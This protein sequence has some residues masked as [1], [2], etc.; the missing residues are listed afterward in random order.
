MDGV[1]WLRAGGFFFRFEEAV[2]GGAVD[3]GVGV[4]L[5][6]RA[7]DEDEGAEGAFEFV[8]VVFFVLAEFEDVGGAIPGGGEGSVGGGARVARHLGFDGLVQQRDG[9]HVVPAAAGQVFNH[10]DFGFICWLEFERQF[11]DHFQKKFIGF[12]RMHDGCGEVLMTLIVFDGQ[13]DHRARIL[14]RVLAARLGAVAARGFDL[15]Y[16]SH[17][18]LSQSLVIKIYFRLHQLLGEFR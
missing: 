6:V 4:A 7:L 3:D 13:G 5:E 18:F 12:A 11:V 15:F 2:G 10:L 16:S 8:A 14:P 17:C 1:I 9:A